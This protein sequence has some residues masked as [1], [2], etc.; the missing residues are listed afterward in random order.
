MQIGTLSTKQYYKGSEGCEWDQLFHHHID[1]DLKS[2][3]AMGYEGSQRHPGMNSE[4][5]LR[6]ATSWRRN[7][8]RLDVGRTAQRHQDRVGRSYDLASRISIK[9]DSWLKA[10]LKLVSVTYGREDLPKSVGKVWLYLDSKDS[11]VS[12]LPRIGTSQGSMGRMCELFDL[13]HK[14]RAGGGRQTRC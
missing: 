5:W 10:F 11:R 9:S 8:T 7:Q 1:R 6:K 3:G 2:K 14:A 12:Q 4:I 13:P